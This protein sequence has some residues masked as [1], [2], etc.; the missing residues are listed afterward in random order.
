ME[1]ITSLIIG[2]ILGLAAGYYLWRNQT[3]NNQTQ[4]QAEL[5]VA[6]NLASEIEKIKGQELAR[7]VSERNEANLR[8]TEVEK[9][10]STAQEAKASAERSLTQLLELKDEIEKRMREAFASASQSQLTQGRADL[11]SAAEE[12]FAPFRSQLDELK[13]TSAEL[14]GSLTANNESAEKVAKEARKLAE[15]MTSTTKQGSWGELQLK[16]VVELTDMLE[17]IDFE[18]QETRASEDGN[19]RP[20]MVIKLPEGKQIIVDAKAPT[21][22]F[23]EAHEATNEA[24]RNRLLDEFTSKIREHAKK[25]GAKEYW[26]QYKPAPE[27]V[28]LFLPNEALFSAALQ[29][30]PSLIEYA[31]GQKVV[32]ATPTTLLSILR[33]IAHS[34]QR[35]DVEKRAEK[36]TQLA[37]KLYEGIR[38]TSEHF[39]DSGKALN[40]A[41][42]YHNKTLST[43]QS[44]VYGNAEKLISEGEQLKSDRKLESGE[45]I[46]VQALTSIEEAKRLRK[47]SSPDNPPG[48]LPSS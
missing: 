17:K 24:D 27:F 11:L 15:A 43:L 19:L 45:V 42:D 23:I 6:K 46:D 48:E 14:K 44:R 18:T 41:V 25:L 4:L 3:G 10:L 47:N 36:V 32:I 39:A 5:L 33:T 40:K 22:N 35:V 16:R 8:L 7:V 20:D 1:I 30:D 31:W 29:I 2:I 28:I 34:W 37:E 12:K 13:K 21:K 9:A 26:N 38:L